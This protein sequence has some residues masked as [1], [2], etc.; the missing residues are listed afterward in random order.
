MP[1]ENP[2]LR[3]RV[4]EPLGSGG[5]GHTFRGFDGD[6]GR[7][8]AIKV[9]SLPKMGDWKRFDL[10]EREVAVL[11]ELQHPSIPLYIDNFASE[12]S[13]DY[14]LVM[15]FIDGTPL[16]RFVGGDRRLKPDQIDDVLRQTLAILDYLHRLA[17]PVIHRD[18][19]PA[20][21]M[22]DR[23]G[24]VHLVDFGGVRWRLQE[25]GHSTV[26]GTFGYLAPEQLHGEASPATDLYSL[27]AT[28]AAVLGGTEAEQLP[29]QGLRID[30]A[31]LAPPPRL[32]PILERMLQPEPTQRYASAA[33]VIAALDGPRRLSEPAAASADPSRSSARRPAPPA[34]ER[35]LAVIPLYAKSLAKTPAPLSILVW[36][37][38]AL[39]S[40]GMLIF[41]VVVV[42]L[43]Y[44]L[45]QS[46]H[47]KH[48]KPEELAAFE[49][50]FSRF[51][52]S[53]AQGRDTAEFVAKRTRPMT[54]S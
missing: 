48:S 38:S 7:T 52:R 28:I 51:K 13:G 45:M 42:P 16:S 53:L 1:T 29:R 11:K 31:A 3:Y 17:P 43:V 2:L 46:Y 50:E 14:F 34:T 41:Q 10:F 26:I 23:D 44:K 6:T 19:K 20:N 25:G 24:R 32:R 12:Q 18:I 8:V 22:L 36:V 30:V 9:L 4:M 27:G 35:G 40:G 33:E 47:R 37:A 5:Q 49:D 21:L 54:E 39:I 15:E